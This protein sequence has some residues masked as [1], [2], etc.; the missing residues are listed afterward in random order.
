MQNTKCGVSSPKKNSQVSARWSGQPAR[1]PRIASGWILL[2]LLLLLI[3]AACGG[4]QSATG[5]APASPAVTSL[6]TAT[7][8]PATPTATSPPVPLAAI[9]NG[10]PI[11]LA[12][13]ERRVAQYEQSMLA[14]GFDPGT[15]EGQAR[16][17]EIQQE[18]LDNMIDSALV[19]QGAVGLGASISDADLEA[20]IMADIEAGGGQAAFDEWLQATGLAREDYKQMLHEALLAQRVMDAV[21]ASLPQ[22]AEQVHA[23]QIVVDSKEVAEQVL[24]ELQV[25][26]DFAAVARERSTDLATKDNGGDL[27]WFP[28]GLIPLELENLAFSLQPG[29]I[30]GPLQLGD[31][32]HFVQVVERDPGRELSPEMQGQLRLVLFER[33]LEEQRAQAI[34]E[35][36]VAE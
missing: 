6:P 1:Q 33:W 4:A 23:R 24:A 13:Y 31:G 27:G 8:Q 35:R 2:S 3:L 7:V 28:R 25:G 34:I 22:A 9:V 26:T 32:Y 15:V 36:L 10:Q 11:L 30:G 17:T 16:L 29:E 18:V 20:Q 14:Q 19:E 21:T 12:D 5:T